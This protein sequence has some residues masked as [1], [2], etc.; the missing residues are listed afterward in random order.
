MAE[1][2]VGRSLT[3]ALKPA[4]VGGIPVTVTLPCNAKNYTTLSA[5][6]VSY[7]V[8][9]YTG[10]ASDTAQA[11]ASYFRN[12]PGTGASAH[13]FVDEDSIFESVKPVNRAWH[14]GTTGAY[15]HAACRNSNSIGIEMCTSGRYLVSDK[16]LRNAAYLTAWWC[17]ALGIATDMVDAYVLRHWDVTGKSC[18][19]QMAGKDNANWVSFKDMVRSILKTGETTGTA[20]AATVTAQ[21]EYPAVPFRVTVSKRASALNVR[22]G[23]GTTYNIVD[24]LKT[25]AAATVLETSPNGWGRIGNGR[26]ISLAW[27]DI[28]ET[29]RA[30]STGVLAVGCEVQFVG[31]KQYVSSYEDAA[32]VKATP[33]T[34]KITL[35]RE[36]GA[37]PY[38]LN[39][40][41][42]SGWVNAADVLDTGRKSVE[43]IAREVA[44][45]DW[46][47]GEIRKARL[48]AAGYN[49]V[50][51]QTIVNTLVK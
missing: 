39:G 17:T 20:A 3:A 41:G 12:T 28:G 5:R 23:A 18:P 42:V 7:I 16:T 51:V 11:N 10:N 8:I 4:E 6:T 29:I 13:Y 1:K 21:T 44:N 46:G 47:D 43:E 25:G 9:H 40:T 38:H 45:G 34:A 15:K 30:V 19:L 37:H 24:K 26:W 50:E 22:E 36:G 32:S 49:P 14:C 48:R 2:T 35:I 33:C 31:A 27:C